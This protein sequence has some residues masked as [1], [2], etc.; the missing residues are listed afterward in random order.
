MIA[1]LER[2]DASRLFAAGWVPPVRERVKAAD[3]KTD[4]YAAYFEPQ[5]RSRVQI[6]DR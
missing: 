2:A 6:S 4:L 1:E 3:G 5:D